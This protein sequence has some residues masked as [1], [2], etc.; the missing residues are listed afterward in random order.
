MK[1]KSD[2]SILFPKFKVVV[3]KYFDFPIKSLY[4]DNGGKFIKLS[5]FLS[6][7][8]ISHFTTPPHTPELNA[9]TE[10]RH[11]HIVETRR[12]L[13]H[14]GKLP[15]EYWTYALMCTATYLINRLSTRILN[16]QTSHQVLHKSTTNIS[17]LHSFR[18]LCFPQLRHYTSNKL[19]RRSHPCIFIGYVESQY[20]YHYLDPT[21]Q[22]IYTSRH[23]KFYDHIFPYPSLTNQPQPMTNPTLASA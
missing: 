23:V 3:E 22:Q 19:Q 6:M 8:G 21:I 7:H 4:S 2:V 18:C 11:R 10:C 5:S 15:S 17:H 1:N 12:A 20:A 16:M 14:T 13:L 9:T